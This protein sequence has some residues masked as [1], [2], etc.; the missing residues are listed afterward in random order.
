[1]IVSSTKKESERN[2]HI[3]V[4]FKARVMQEVPLLSGPAQNVAQLLTLPKEGEVQ[5]IAERRHGNLHWYQVTFQRRTGFV[6]ESHIE[7]VPRP[8]ELVYQKR[9]LNL[10]GLTDREKAKMK[11]F[12]KYDLE[13][14]DRQFKEALGEN[15]KYLTRPVNNA[16]LSK[17]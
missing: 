4:P 9:R 11:L 2:D 8:K 1:M 15:T 7:E 12:E 6:L 16:I 14:R 13:R 17:Y 10:S 5:V 3:F